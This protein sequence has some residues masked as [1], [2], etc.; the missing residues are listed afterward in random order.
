MRR[1]PELF[2]RRTPHHGDRR[3]AALLAAADELLRERSYDEITIADVTARA[4]VTRS[5]FYFYFENKAACVAALGAGM[6]AEAVGAADHLLAVAEPPETRIR[7]MVDA[8]FAVWEAHEY[9]YRAVLEASRTSHVLRE[10]W[11]G[12]RESF[13]APVAALVEDERAAGRALPGPDAVTLATLLLDLSDRTLERLDAADRDG[14]RR[15]ARTLTTIWLRSLYGDPAS[16][17][18]HPPQQRR[19]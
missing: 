3:R 17:S 13:V 7:A 14:I 15:H 4:G 18:G 1:E 11:D 10:L 8:L 12:Y 6:Y 5:A 16:V 9:L 19:R 2:D